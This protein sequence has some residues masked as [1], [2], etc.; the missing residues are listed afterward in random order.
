[1]VHGIDHE[2]I[3]YYLNASNVLVLAS[4]K[5]GSPN[6]IKEALACNLP[7]VS[8]DVGDVK[9]LT[10]GV[11]G[12]KIVARD[13]NAIAKAVRDILDNFKR[14]NG[15]TVIQHLSLESVAEKLIEF[16]RHIIASKMFEKV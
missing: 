11:Q 9:E 12:C 4:I 7:I 10:Q 6:I 8:T 1:M 5:E 3:P 2:A 15:R 16:Y 13:K 14:T